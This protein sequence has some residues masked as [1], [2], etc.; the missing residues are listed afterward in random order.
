MA[1]APSC[2]FPVPS[3]ASHAHEL[4]PDQA[5][6]CNTVKA[7]W[8]AYH[9]TLE[10]A[11]VVRRTW[12]WLAEQPED[13]AELALLLFE[14]APKLN[15]SETGPSRQASSKIPRQ[16]SY[17]EQGGFG[18]RLARAVPM[19]SGAPCSHA[20]LIGQPRT[21]HLARAVP[22]L[23]GDAPLTCTHDSATHPKGLAPSGPM[24]LREYPPQE[25]NL[26]PGMPTHRR[27]ILSELAVPARPGRPTSKLW[28]LRI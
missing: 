6:L 19:P 17:K 22:I 27:G 25:G 13:A 4:C 18:Q 1:T 15:F 14:A 12:D 28:R 3:I 8:P 10:S 20:P 2:L 7:I 23:S 9:Q 21:K 5:L 26:G 11:Q 24:P 16:A